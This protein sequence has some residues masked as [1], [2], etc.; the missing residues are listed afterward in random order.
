MGNSQSPDGANW[1]WP[2]LDKHP[3]LKNK[4]LSLW[5]CGW[6][7]WEWL[8]APHAHHLISPYGEFCVFKSCVRN[9]CFWEA[10]FSYLHLNFWKRWPPSPLHDLSL[11]CGPLVLTRIRLTGPQ[12]G[13]FKTEILQAS[14]SEILSLSLSGWGLSKHWRTQGIV[15]FWGNWTIL[16]L[17]KNFIV[18]G[19][20]LGNQNVFDFSGVY[21]CEYCI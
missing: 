7:E 4:F 12:A 11:S 20:F 15:E 14:N 17:N 18:S 2:N 21:D 13:H 19:D 10:N 6:I 16:Q 9:T 3:A 1:C 8:L 5:N